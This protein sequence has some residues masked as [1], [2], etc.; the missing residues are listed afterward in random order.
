MDLYVHILDQHLPPFPRPYPL[1][2]T[3]TLIND[4]LVAIHFIS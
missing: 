3:F 4:Q 2:P 1:L